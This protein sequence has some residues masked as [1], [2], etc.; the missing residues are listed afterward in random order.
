[1]PSDDHVTLQDATVAQ[2]D[3]GA[4]DTERTY[5]HIAAQLCLRIDMG[6]WRNAA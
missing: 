1:M 6:Q 2:D 4:D 5:F 3:I